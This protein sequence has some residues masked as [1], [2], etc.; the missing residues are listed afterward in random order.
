LQ[1]L[2]TLLEKG[3]D[4]M[5]MATAVDEQTGTA[6]KWVLTEELGKQIATAE[7]LQKEIAANLTEPVVGF[8]H[9]VSWREPWL[10]CLVVFHTS[11]LVLSIVSRKHS[12]MQMGIFFLAFLGV[13]S[14][15][16][17]NSFLQRHWKHFAYQPYFDSQGLFLST[18]WSGPLLVVSSLIL[19]NSL[20]TFSTLV[21]KWKRAMQK[22]E[23]KQLKRR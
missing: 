23:H 2:E 1:I 5:E 9:A 19:V 18:V 10:I 14:A 21:L 13:F 22:M 16:R 15:E 3:L 4:V 11:L 20:L 7:V 17:L 6:A 8:I 12:N